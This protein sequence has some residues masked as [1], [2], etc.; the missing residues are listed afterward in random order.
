MSPRQSP[1]RP[2]SSLHPD[3]G[4]ARGRPLR[5]PRLKPV[6][7]AV[8]VLLLAGGAHAQRALGPAWMAQKNLAQSTAAATGRLPNGLP[9]SSLN[10]PLAQQQQANAQLARSIDNLNLAARGIAAQ[11]AAQAAARAAALAA[12]GGVPDGLTEGGLKVDTNSLT[13]GWLNANAPTQGSADGRT[14]VAIQQT[15]DKAIL[16]WETFNVGR[17]TTVEFKQQADWAVLNRVNDPNARPSQIQGQLKS[18]GTVLVVNRNGIVFS[19]S[20]QVNTRNLVAAAVGMSDAQF[21][22][23]LYSS[24]QGTTPVPV[25][26]NDLV[27]TATSVAHGNATADVVVEAGA[28]IETRTPQSVTEGGGYVLLAGREVRNGGSIATPRGQTTLAAGDAFVIRKG[29]GTDGNAQSSTRGNEVEVLRNAG[30]AAGRV[31]NA[32]LIGAAT[33]DVTLS[34]HTVEQAGVLLSSTSVNARGTLHLTATGGTDARVVLAP[35]G[36]SAI[37]LDASAETAL[38]VQR[39]ALIKESAVAS[40]E[41]YNRRDLSLV[42]VASS[43][44]VAFEPDSLTLATGGQV[45]VTAARRTQVA[46]RASID[47][48]G[49]VGVRLAMASNNVEINVQGNEQRDAPV[50]RDTK[51]L[52]NATVWID[53]RYLVRVPA[54]TD[55]YE[56]ERWYT[57]GGLLEV[58]G[59]LN[60]GGHTIGEWAAAGGTVDFGGGELLTRA[61]SSINV[62]GG[63]LDVQTGML[64]QTWLTGADG[65]LYNLSTAPGDMLYRGVYRG[66]ES[67]HARWGK[68]ATEYF[69]SP[70]IGMQERLESGYTVGRDAG[71]VVVGTR[72][73]V[74]EGGIDTTVYQGPRQQQARDAGLDG[75]AQ[76]QIAAARAGRLIVGQLVPVYDGSGNTLRDSATPLAERI[77]IGKAAQG[78]AEAIALADAWPQAASGRIVLDADWLNGL[79]LGGLALYA[80]G[81]IEVSEA[82]VV[83]P[84]GSIA[85]HA[86]QV[87]VK[88]DLGARGGSIALGNM[89]TRYANA[90]WNEVPL[91]SAPPAGYT[92]RVTLAEGVTLDTRGLWTNLLRDPAQSRGLPYVD[93][94]AVRIASTGDVL[95]AKGSL[96]DTSSGAAL[97]ADGTQRGGRGG[98]IALRSNQY[99]TAGSGAGTLALDGELRGHGMKGGGTLTIDSGIGIALGGGLLADSGVLPAGQAVPVHLTLAEAFVIPVGTVLPSDFS[100]TANVIPAGAGLK[101]QPAFSASRTVT[102][103]A[104]WVVPTAV[105]SWEQIRIDTTDGMWYFNGQ[106]IPAGKTIRGIGGSG[107]IPEGYI[108]PAN[109]FPNG[110]PVTDYLITIEAGTPFAKEVTMAA[111]QRIAAGTRLQADAAVK[112]LVVLGDSLFRSGF[113]K[114]AIG[115][116]QGVQVAQDAALEITMP[117]LRLDV[118]AARTL[119]TGADPSAALQPW[120]PPLWQQNPA[121]GVLTQRAGADIALT[122]GT[123]YSQAPLIVGTGASLAVDPGRAITL[124]G[125]G[126][127]TVDGALSAHGGRISVL[128]GGF[129]TGNDANL[130]AGRP[131]GRSLWIGA[132]A[133]LD[134]SGQAVTAIDAAG[135][136]YGRVSAGGVIELGARYDAEARKLDAIEA[137]L[138]VRPGAVLEAS[139]ASALLEV[140]GLGP[141]VVASHGGTLSLSSTRGLFLDGRMHAA[142]GG[143]GAAGGTLALQ[144]ETPVYG[145]VDRFTFKGSNVDD[146]VRVPRELTL[147]QVQG[148]SGLAAGLVAAQADASL[149]YGQARLGADRVQ[150]GGFDNLAL[151]ANGLISFDGDVTLALGQSLR[152]TA[153]SMGLAQGAAADSRVQLS[154]P[155]VRLAGSS[156]RQRDNTIMPNPVLGS[157]NAG[158][159]KGS[160][161]VPLVA[162]GSSLAIDA[163]LIDFVGEVNTGTR[164]TIALNAATPLTVERFA[165]DDMR[166]YSS[167]DMRFRED[168]RFYA[169][170]NLRLVAAQLY[171]TTGSKALVMV[172]QVSS[173]DTWGNLVASFDPARSLTIERSSEADPAVPYSVFGSLTLA[174]GTVHQGGVVRAPLGNVVFGTRADGYTGQVNLLPGSI[175]SVS[176]HGLTMPYGGT[177]DGLTYVYNGVDLDF[178]GV[179]NEPAVQFASHAV[180]V[181]EGAVIDLR[182]G[183]ELTGAGF[184]TGRGGSTDA[185]LHP[186]VQSGAK[187][188]FTLPGL[189]TNPVYAIVPGVQAGYAPIVAEKGAGDPAIGRQIT[190]GAGVPGLAA[191]TYTLLPSSYALLPGAYRVELSGKGAAVTDTAIAMR[192]GSWSAGAQ[193]DV[194]HTQIRDALPMQV[195]LTSADTLRRYS[196]YNETGVSAFALGVAEREGIPRAVIERDAKTL[197]LDLFSPTLAGAFEGA[198]RALQFDGTVQQAP[199][200]GG[201]GSTL[202]LSGQ[203]RYEVLAAGA[204]PTAGFGGVSVHAD[205]LNAVGAAR[206]VIGGTLKATFTNN[207]GSQQSANVVDAAATASR[208]VLRAGSQLEAA[209]VFLLT[210]RIDGGITLEQGSGIDTLRRGAPAYDSTQGY[211]YATGPNSMLALSNGW[212][213]VLA[214][215]LPTQADGTGPGAIHIGACD[216][217]VPCSGSTRLYSEGTITAATD[218]AFTLADSVRYG[219]RN[220]VL[221]VGGINVGSEAALA[222]AAA[223]GVLPEG[224]TLNQQVLDRLLLGDT[225]VGAPA[226]ENLVLTARDA[227]NFFGSTALSTI[228]PATGRSALQRLVLGTPAIYG[229]GGAGDVARIETDTLVW[230]GAAT[231]PGQVVAQGAGTGTGSGQLRVDA[232]QIEFGFG[233]D[234]RVD[235]VRAQDRLAL[236]FGEVALH[237]SERIT[238]NH[239]GTLAVYQ[240]RGAWDD[241]TK[242][243]GYSGGVLDIRTPLLTG[244]AGSVNRITAGGD[245]R[246]GAPQGAAPAKSDNALLAGALGAEIALDSRGGSVVF[247]TA[248][249]LPSGKLSLSA[250]GDVQLGAGAQL[251]LAGRRIDFFDVSKYSWGGDVLLS[252][253]AG[254]IRQAAG[255][256]IDLSADDNR[257]GK[258]SAIALGAGAGTVDLAG[259]IDGNASGHYD[260]GGTRVPYAAGRIEV[261]GQQIADFA[262]LNQRL[263]AG[264][265]VGGRAFQL[266]QGDLVIGSELKAREIDVSVDNGRL[267]VDGRIDASGEQAGSIRLAA[268]G[269]VTLA[270]TAVLDAHAT[271]LRVDSY[272][273][274]IEAPNRAVIEI[275]AGQGR[276]TIADGARMDLRAGQSRQAFGTV[277][278][279]AARL[280]GNDVDI[281]AA[282]RIAINGARSLTLNAFRTY[283]DAALGTDATNDGRS[284]QV[285]DQAYLDAKHGDSARFIDA[286]LGNAGLMDGRLAGLRAYREQFHLRPGVV[287]AADT[288]AGFNPDGNLH[289]DGDIDLSGHRYASVNPSLQR[290]LVRGSGEAGALVL[291]AAGDL[292]IFGSLSDGF[293]GG[294][295]G[296]TPDDKGWILPKGRIPWGGDVVLPHGQRVTL[297]E[298]TF[299]QSGRTLN[300]DLPMQAMSFAANTLLPATVTLAE[301][302][303]I[304]AGT[305]LGGEVRDASGRLL[306]AA[307]T[308]LQQNLVLPA[309]TQLGAGLR[310]PSA[311]QVA[312]MLWPKGVPLPFPQGKVQDTAD[313]WNP[314]NG[315][316]LAGA[317]TLRKGSVIPG[318]TWVRLP[319]D[320]ESVALRPAD[321]V[322]GTQGRTWALAPMLAPGSASWDL[323]LVA[324]ADLQAADTRL[325]VPGSTAQVRLSDTHYG[326]ASEYLPVPGTGTPAV[327]RWSPDID[328]ATWESMG[329]AGVFVP[330]EL[331]TP[332]TIDLLIAMG[333]IASSPLELNDWGAGATTDVASPG[334]PAD[335]A[336]QMRPVRQ[337]LYSVLRTGTG[338]LDI[339]SAGNVAMTSPFG[340]YT[341]GT[342]AA[343]LAAPGARDPYNLQRGVNAEGNVLKSEGHYLEQLVD[344]GSQSLYQAWYPERGGNVLVRA[345]GAV[346]G[347][348][349][350]L[351]GNLNRT[352]DAFGILDNPVSSSVAIGNWLWRQGTGSVVPGAEGVPTAWWINF[353]T[354]VA[355]DERRLGQY[356]NHPSLVGF[357]GIGTL[358]GG[359]LV[360]ESAGNAGVLSQRGDVDRNYV[361]RSQGLN[362]AVA[363]TG[364]MTAA[365][366]LLL[367]GGGDLDVRIGGRLNPAREVRIATST[368]GLTQTEQATQL[369]L[370][371]TFVNLRGA[372]NLQAGA[373]GSIELRYD[374]QDPQES[375]PYRVAVASSSRAGGGPVI[376]P[377]DAG[378]RIDAR[379]DLVLGSVV[380]AGRVPQYYDGFRFSY[381]GVQRTGQGWAWF[382]LWTPSTALDLFSAGGN[383]TP[384]TAWL[385]N[386]S[387]RDQAATDGR[388]VYPSQLRAVAASGSLYYGNAMS[389]ATN[390]GVPVQS[391]FGIVLAPSPVAP[392]F[393]RTHA[394]QLELLAADSIHAG[395]YAITPSGADPTALPTPYNTGFSGAVRLAWFGIGHANHVPVDAHMPSVGYYT[396]YGLGSTQLY[397]M[398][399]LTSP[400]AS[401]YVAE[402]QQPARYY[403]VDGDA[404]GVRTG[405]IVTRGGRADSPVWYEGGGAVAIMAGRDI[406]NSGTALGS[407]AG[408]SADGL[409]WST[410][411]STVPSQLGDPP[412]ITPVTSG[413]SRGNLIVHNSPDDVSVVSAGRDIRYSSFYVAGPGTLEVTAGRDLYMADK[414]ELRSLGAIV[415]VT[416]G[417][418]SGGASIVAAAGMGAQG[419]DY[420]AF[421]ARYL[422]PANQADLGRAFADQPG[423]VLYSYGGE[424][425]LGQW[426]KREFGYAGDEAGAAGFLATRQAEIDQARRAALA[427]GGTAANRSLARE[428]R[429]ESQ[430]HLVNW[431][432]GLFGGGNGQRNGLGL[433]FD[434]ATMDAR[435]FFDALPAAQQRSF[436]RNVYY[437]ELKAAGRE[438]TAV[439]GP[440]EGSYLRGREAIATL[441]P[442]HDAQ[443]R[444]IE[445]SGDLTMFSSAQYFDQYVGGTMTRRP[446]PGLNYL[447][448]DEWQAQGSP[449]YYVPY[450]QVLDAGIHTD[451]G[452]DISLMVPGGRALVGV[453]GGFT[454]AEGSGLLT[455]GAGDIQVYARGSLL[456]GQSRVFT[457]F[458]GSILAWSAEGDI[459]AGRGSKTTVVYT[460]Q[461]RLYDSIG[462]V[463]LSPSTPN[464]GAGIATLNPIPEIPPGDIDLIAPMGTIDAGEAGIRVSGNV[465]LAALHVVNAENIQVQG[466]AVGIPV[467]AAVNVGALSNASAAAAQ[468][469]G[470]AQE[471]MQRERAAARQALPSVF[472]VRVLGFGNEP[473]DGGGARSSG[474]PT[475]APVGYRPESAVQVLGQ[476]GRV[477]EGACNQLT[478]AERRTLAL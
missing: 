87:D 32:G 337:Q 179:G 173:R 57:G 386:G 353:G 112:P 279:N 132:G 63:T 40:D 33:G 300:Y 43:G 398:F 421:A 309:N 268:N 459:N 196:Q 478:P 346:T 120:L 426:L 167:G 319:G 211:V 184:L 470:A 282:G 407:T 98:D 260:A 49:A 55:G 275:D 321:A 171:P 450:Y 141:T 297:A 16:N 7:A 397:P 435:A 416:P 17:N 307:G 86:S 162:A 452:G 8:V 48:S 101:G 315:V 75:Y 439:G 411:R 388:F 139:G 248:V 34:G 392:E 385:D 342:Q 434:A 401:G 190:I 448:Y 243:Y 390:N 241:S 261:R 148:D 419:A 239:L 364:R 172:G 11:Q 423:K 237:A 281:D 414:A 165:F 252:S 74:L 271:V 425:T 472:T 221:A 76:S 463:S 284:Y 225:S 105:V 349:I 345:G 51:L 65:R 460:P 154:A 396:G 336:D 267:T 110:M 41:S 367:T 370:N 61:G 201:R 429:V 306:H 68:G 304:A 121:K 312:A 256:A 168:A 206:I 210:G 24:L 453:D 476:A 455:Q 255:S 258:L 424:L 442:S 35:G 36:V 444:A 384:G 227:L 164:G 197:R 82:V 449:S 278:L 273:K 106:M 3:R 387:N 242:D 23:G 93:G 91:V 327:Y 313:P 287:I 373:I 220:L 359:N 253:R 45:N 372:M 207:Q 303:T 427:A 418:R 356:Q 368:A 144:L 420:R 465:N 15:A 314:I 408:E 322:D 471:V 338:D 458:G 277:T 186:L 175:S 233:P 53:R 431:L 451:F 155:Y 127:I 192:N 323:R 375:R 10:S 28:R 12:G 189:A 320:A 83:V 216:A 140:A 344:G 302:V 264:G 124:T 4:A 377:G 469:A 30:S 270:G 107:K 234:L 129:G 311:I 462:L 195:T 296:V 441:L 37:L 89:T 6:T 298:G 54:G 71:R 166:L 59:Y 199:A 183:G 143:A 400:S 235:S 247:D 161:G 88:A 62:A 355:G 150:A 347:D 250:Q 285:I 240:S 249:L 328:V 259:R 436:L 378:V 326:L 131:D 145:P 200:K 340:V 231:P 149:V 42:Q 295:L 109:A 251:D 38:D 362:L 395:G 299:F 229:L 358:G 194:A 13:A 371:G 47:V 332:E 446:K 52:N 66:F 410:F 228:D 224:L 115:A 18:D 393:T 230:N 238:A 433:H 310:L 413:S 318:E 343:S 103:A 348:Q 157:P 376:V 380:D 9:V 437:A 50:N 428:Y 128:P 111:G 26:A 39:N 136:T 330:G 473:V 291:R 135:R 361:P 123:L 100:Y 468:A 357:T 341:A 64:R 399:S 280:G 222:E 301:A 226:L 443:G 205:D 317:L 203:G 474:A 405:A 78:V 204:A 244:H 454:P 461:R 118:P 438:Y 97:M 308:L 147:S 467:V 466:K 114:Y 117:V 46:E 325:T 245:I 19:G 213:D 67:E 339:V 202:N 223:R 276:L 60:T 169:P 363:S 2:V 232:R 283:T 180:D 96:I 153:S 119:A 212:L 56:A 92:A 406:V 79:G 182:G 31:V 138:I 404:I 329:L 417:D 290:T 142:A 334:T 22:Q 70:L 188:G 389:G 80:S 305:V 394:G 412:R 257:A 125:N 381:D 447:R 475:A 20:S 335:Y 262:G 158:A 58:G 263:N 72:S 214:P 382:S 432:S 177:V 379:G 25:L 198:G 160:L 286:A 122:A 176:A 163:A 333:Y 85:L 193:L 265:V 187:G 81:A 159:G 77:D 90:A 422:D 94:G 102:L 116:H 156:G 236:G 108:V 246:V 292:E 324:G 29:V 146:A 266:R 185:R 170:G 152:L 174:A 130:P 1:A 219:A 477:D 391:P 365:G 151:L 209:E 95:L 14:T 44:D 133:V 134:V 409:G 218:K 84:G 351:R 366:E 215:T 208:I 217:G 288:R 289:V 191:G 21:G 178:Q 331:I 254:H 457:T 137:F 369:D 269:G 104:P 456:L 352:D 99:D 374:Q 5:S 383:L 126:Q 181:R 415:N 272:G 430:L 316:Q 354:Y 445:R 73:A 113:S 360:F 69:H 294:R 403:A 27:L 293:D 464:T 350:G 440:R 402:G 274:V